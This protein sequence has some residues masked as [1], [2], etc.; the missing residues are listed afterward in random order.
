MIKLPY[1]EPAGLG[2]YGLMDENNVYQDYMI[3]VYKDRAEV[4]QLQ[5]KGK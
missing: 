1:E 4:V 3:V 5:E 2:V